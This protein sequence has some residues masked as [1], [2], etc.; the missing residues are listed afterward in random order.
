MAS[1]K[2]S[3]VELYETMRRA[4]AY[5]RAHEGDRLGAAAVA[6]VVGMSPSR[7]DHAFRE[8]VGLSPKRFL[9]YLTK[10][11]AKQLLKENPDVLRASHRAG[12]SGGGRLHDLFVTQEGVSPG[13]WKHGK[14][15]IRF[16]IHSS[17]FG[18]CVIGVTSRGVAALAFLKKRDRKE[19]EKEIR[20]RWPNAT[21]IHDERSSARFHERIFFSGK[22]KGKIPL[23]IRGTNFQVKVWEALL[24]IPEGNV[25]SYRDIARMIGSP[26]AVRAVGSACGNNALALLIPC[27]R[28]LTSEGALGGY[29][30]GVDRKETILA[31]EA[32]RG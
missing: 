8:W 3:P 30:W 22:R 16:G 11:R 2:R 1:G 4:I 23:V 7:F 20:S 31:W 13:E 17:P 6:K 28:V 9:S 21:I 5:L 14:V 24:S 15:E 29:R 12:L 26:K 19:A 25:A 27:H 10:E 32:A 18:W